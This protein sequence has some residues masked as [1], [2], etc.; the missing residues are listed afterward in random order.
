MS[1][2]TEAYI[3]QLAS[4]D[5]AKQAEAAEALAQLGPDAQPAAA[6]LVRVCGSEDDSVREWATSA[7]EGLG[8][9]EKEQMRDLDAW[10]M[11]R[12]LRR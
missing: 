1:D 11:L 8:P 12:P 7:L 9:P 3:A 6:A 4:K 2:K 5:I 10:A